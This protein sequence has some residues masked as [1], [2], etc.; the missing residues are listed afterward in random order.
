M[1]VKEQ[2]EKM[3]ELIKDSEWAKRLSVWVSKKSH[4]NNI[5]DF[6]DDAEAEF[7]AEV[8][9][10]FFADIQKMASKTATKDELFPLPE[11]V[12]R[13]ENG[14]RSPPKQAP[15]PVAKP[16]AEPKSKVLP[17]FPIATEAPKDIDLKELLAR[18][19]ALETQLSSLQRGE[20]VLR[21]PNKPDKV[22]CEV[23]IRIP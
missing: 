12:M 9:E 15:R 23:F 4:F 21:T 20:I 2:E 7:K 13:L 1:T 22:L 8:I 14:D 16:V 5:V 3:R 19:Q 11:G 17:L 6:L 18:V 10:S